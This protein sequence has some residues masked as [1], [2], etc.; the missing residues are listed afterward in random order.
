VNFVPTVRGIFAGITHEIRAADFGDLESVIRLVPPD[1]P[2][3]L[4]ASAA[5]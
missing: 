1:L 5:T 2:A 4:L 3:G